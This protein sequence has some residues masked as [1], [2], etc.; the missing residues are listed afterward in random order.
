MQ[1]NVQ[2]TKRDAQGKGASRRL[3]RAG[4]TPGIIYGNN[5]A[6][7]QISLDHNN[8]FHALR[9]EAFHSSVLSIDVEGAKEAVLLRDVQWHPFRQIVLHV[10]FQR[11]DA[12]HA[13]H[14][15]LPLH[16]INAD[17]CPG[18]KLAGGTVSHTVNEVDVK[19]LASEMPSFIEVD[20]KSLEAGSAVHMR[21]LVLPKGVE[22]AHATDADKVVASLIAKRGGDDAAEAPADAAKA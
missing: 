9:N 15:R 17:V 11:V 20:L 4:T 7:I 10:D 2:A 13:I 19:A 14:V 18:V 3:R 12:T 5:Q 16:F 8:L 21:D 6:A 1:F 22:L